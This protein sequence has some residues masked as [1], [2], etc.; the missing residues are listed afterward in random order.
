MN[1]AM[2]ALIRED[3]CIGV[4][5]RSGAH[6]D[7]IPELRPLGDRVLIK[8][9]ET[10]DVTVGGVVLTEASKERPLMGEVV[11]C[12]PGKAVRHPS[13]LKILLSSLENSY[14]YA[15]CLCVLVAYVDDT[16]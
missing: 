14:T 15:H 10:A 3:D 7:D 11:R 6:A 1:G 13:S 16:G 2:Y 9:T 4:M 5:P 12:G 8:V